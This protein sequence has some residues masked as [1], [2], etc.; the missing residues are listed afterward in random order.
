MSLLFGNCKYKGSDRGHNA[1]QGNP[2][3]G[4]AVK[5][6]GTYLCLGGLDIDYVVLLQVEIGR[7]GYVGFVQVKVIYP[8]H[9]RGVFTEQLHVIAYREEGHIACLC[10]GLE[11]GDFFGISSIGAWA[12]YFAQYAELVV[13]GTHGDVGYFLEVGLKLFANQGFTFAVGQAHYFET[14]QYRKIDTTLII[15]QIGQ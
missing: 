9:T 12:S 13:G 7:L 3:G 15:Y 2:H 4:V 5:G 10:Q 11:D 8:T 14:P 6:V 1:E